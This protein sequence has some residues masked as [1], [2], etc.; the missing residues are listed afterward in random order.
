M[1]RRNP[2]RNCYTAEELAGALGR[3]TATLERW[4]LNGLGPPFTKIGNITLYRK[5]SLEKWLEEREVKR[6][7]P[8]VKGS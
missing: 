3:T 2:F 5:E 6:V 1:R 8:E 4:T 7:T